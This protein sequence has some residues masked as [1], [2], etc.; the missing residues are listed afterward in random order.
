M[1]K[2][3]KEYY[4][5]EHMK[6]IQRELGIENDGR[7]KLIEQFQ[8]RVAKTKLPKPVQT[9]FDEVISSP[10]FCLPSFHII[11]AG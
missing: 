6:G 4:L 7:R 9:V 5:M 11:G 2:A 1:E 10:Y 8:E 3:K